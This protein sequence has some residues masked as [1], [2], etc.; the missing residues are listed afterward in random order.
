MPSTSCFQKLLTAFACV[1][2]INACSKDDDP[3]PKVPTG[4]VTQKEIN[5]WILDSMRYFYLWDASLPATADTQL[6]TTAFFNSLKNNADRFSLLYNPNDLST[7]P[8]SMLFSYGIDFTVIDWPKAP[9]GAIGIVKLVLPRSPAEQQGLKRGSYFTRINGTALSSSNAAG[10]SDKLLQQSSASF[11]LATATNDNVTEDTTITLTAQTLGEEPIYG[12][13]VFNANGK[14]VAYLFYNYFN[15]YY[16]ESLIA[17]FQHFKTAGASELILDLRY[18]PGGSVTAAAL[19]AALIAPNISEQSGFVKFSGN[20]RMGERTVSFQSA[21]SVPEG[22]SPVT[23]SSLGS[24]R[25]S[26][27]RVFILAGPQTASA[28]ELVINNLKPY[29]QVILIGQ[30][31]YGKDKGAVTIS[32]LRKPQR[33]PW[34]L[35][36]ITY[37]LSNVNGE[38][39]YIQGLSPQ[40][41]VNEMSY[42][43]LSAVG[44]TGDPLIAKALSILNGGGRQTAPVRENTA[45]IFFDSR[46]QAAAGGVVKVPAMLVR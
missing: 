29:T 42:Q 17:A 33:I 40:Y 30:N 41:A 4:P 37:N 7:Y 24:A 25:L 38:G 19:L 13:S 31:T 21:L 12:Q 36:P 35:L 45:R 11:T 32:D 16:N 8:K 3:G 10:L 22:G 46:Q 6:S 44:N 18:N 1:A 2:L 39:G 9:A 43:P 27:Q 28:A 23:F 34:V 5:N 26:L 20:A 15:D 14:K